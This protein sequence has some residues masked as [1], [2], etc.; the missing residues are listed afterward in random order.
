MKNI[1]HVTMLQHKQYQKMQQ[2]F[3]AT[4]HLIE[5]PSPHFHA[6][7]LHYYMH[8]K[9][10]ANYIVL[11]QRDDL[12]IEICAFEENNGITIIKNLQKLNP[13]S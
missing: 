13:T 11:F 8:K 7:S 1:V 2:V 6:T 12:G 3:P 5:N 4:T 9:F 10:L